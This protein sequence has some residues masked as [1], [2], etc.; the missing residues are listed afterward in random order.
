[1]I[2]SQFMSTGRA[3]LMK[4][5]HTHESCETTACPRISEAPSLGVP[6]SEREPLSGPTFVESREGIEKEPS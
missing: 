2:R 5:G 3:G 6:S 4:Y 1:M